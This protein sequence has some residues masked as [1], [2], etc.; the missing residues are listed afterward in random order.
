MKNLISRKSL[1]FLILVSALGYFVDVYDLILFSVVR[2]KSLLDLGV[3]DSESLSVGLRLLNYQM[4]GLLIGGILFGIIGDRKGRLTVLFGSIVVYSIANILNG[5]IV[6]ISQYE[7]LRIVAGIGLAGELGAGI[8]IVS[9]SMS[10]KNR[11]YGTMIIA[12]VGLLG[13]VVASY[14]G[15]NYQWRT[16][17]IV[18]GC[19]GI[20]LLILRIG[21]YESGLYNKIKNS[22]VRKGNFLELF[23]SWQK[24]AKY[25]KSIL[26]G[27]PSYF[28][29]GLL[30]TGSPEFGKAFKLQELPIAGLVIM[31]FYIALSI[32]DLACSSFSQWVKSR[33]KAFFLF[34]GICL[35]GI[36]IFL[37]APSSDLQGFYIRC[38]VMGFGVGFWA[39]I[40]TNAAEQFGT[41]L[42]AT[43]ATTVPNFVRGALVP[44][45]FCF[46]AL[47]GHIG[48][49]N[50][51]GA[52][53][54]SCVIIALIATYYTKETFGKELDY[55][56]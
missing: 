8:T 39:L 22:N 27:L 50:A 38:F 17:F 31:V 51:A 48:L 4:V 55:V 5:F 56:E 23:T 54:I 10:A 16:A 45:T 18:G 34:N 35:V 14:V 11:G 29:I 42:R 13:A 47:K 37:Y 43:V 7:I 15:L 26:V 49:I 32:G 21:V 25:G 52:I 1:V 19:M 2:K 9:E 20:F 30:V 53:G 40:T 3:P 28:I 12:A 24:F 44:I 33:R 41:N 36:I 46:E 6:N